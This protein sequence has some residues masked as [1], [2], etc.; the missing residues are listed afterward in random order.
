MVGRWQAGGGRQQSDRTAQPLGRAGDRRLAAATYG[1]R[2][3]AGKSGVVAGR[4]VDRLSVG[5]RRKRAMG[6]VYGLSAEWR[7][8]AA[9]ALAGD[10]GEQSGVVAGRTPVGVPDQAANIAVARGGDSWMSSRARRPPL[11]HDTPKGLSNF[12]AIWSHDGKWIAYTQANA[13]GDDAN[14]FLVEVATGKSENLTAHEGAKSFR[15]A[16][17]S[18]DGKQLLV[19]S[20]AENGFPNVALLDVAT[21]KLDWLTHEKWEVRAG[22]FAPDGKSLTWTANTDGVVDVYRYDV[23]TRKAE[24]LP[25]PTGVNGLAGS[26]TAFSKDGTHLLYAHEGPEAPEDIWSYSF[27]TKQSTQLTHSMSAAL[28]PKD[29]VTPYLVHY[30]SRD[31][32]YTISAWAYMPYNIGRNNTFPAIVWIHGGPAGQTMDGFNPFM[33]YILNQGYIVIAPNYRGSTGYGKDF[34]HAN[35]MDM[36]GG[37]LEDNLAGDGFHPEDWVCGSEEADRDG[38]QLWRLHDDDGR[39]QSSGKVGGRC[40]HRAFRELVH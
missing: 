19:T 27:T 23:A 7:S 12:H 30:P 25:F 18:P 8:G 2:A 5:L 21:K 14:V 31:G 4:K 16:S 10:C 9:H 6:P 35:Y 3:A 1:Q 38:P 29:M 32:K 11:T 34:E 28:D 20:D 33:Q 39:H 40:G 17:F 24:R 36:G 15:A 37:D 26:D 22:D 13:K